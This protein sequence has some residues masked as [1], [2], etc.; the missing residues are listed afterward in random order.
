MP[1]HESRSF[2]GT[3]THIFGHRFVIRTEDSDV[4]ADLTP[5]GVEQIT[6]RLHDAVR[7]EGE[8]KPSEL[9]V[10]RLT[11]GGETIQIDHPK[12]PHHDAH[13]DSSVALAAAQSAAQSAGYAI[14][15]S[16][17]RKPKHF[18]LLGQRN[19]IFNELHIALDGHIRKSKPVDDLDQKWSS[20]LSSAP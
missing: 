7:V 17:R 1:H 4:L 9:K 10:S 6:L 8:M 3:V 15:G 12:K 16:P 5:R 2:S 14:V 20:E 18:E 11:R 13:A 19:G